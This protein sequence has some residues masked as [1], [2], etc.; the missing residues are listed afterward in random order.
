MIALALLLT[1]AGL[2]TLRPQTVLQVPDEVRRTNACLSNLGRIAHAFAQYA[3]DYDGKF[4][5]GVDPEDR[6]NP[7]LWKSYRLRAAGFG[8]WDFSNDARTAPMLHELLWPY[9]RERKVWHCPADTGWGES[10]MT[11]LGGGLGALRNV[12]PSSWARFG[13]SYYYLTIRG[14][15]GWK[16][17]DFSDPARTVILFDGDMWHPAERQGHSINVLCADGHAENLQATEFYRRMQRPDWPDVAPRL[18]PRRN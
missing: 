10:S 5:R 6:N 11:N 16:A 7:D 9:I 14:F 18:M 12:R 8:M 4:P 13:T 3:Q 2:W 15:A 17:S 1:A